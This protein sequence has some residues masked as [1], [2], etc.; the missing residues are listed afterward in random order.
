MNTGEFTGDELADLADDFNDVDLAPSKS[1]EDLDRALFPPA[2][3]D[4]P[5]DMSID[6]FPISDNILPSPVRP[7]ILISPENK[8]MDVNEL[9]NVDQN[10]EVFVKG[11][12]KLLLELPEYTDDTI[13]EWV[14]KVSPLCSKNVFNYVYIQTLITRLSQEYSVSGQNTG[15]AMR[16]ISAELQNAVRISQNGSKITKPFDNAIQ[17]S[18]KEPQSDVIIFISE[19]SGSEK[20][21]AGDIVKVYKAY[22]DPDHAP[23][24][25]CLQ[26]T[27][28][29]NVLL[30]DVFVKGEQ[31][32]Q[33]V[34][35]KLYL[36]AYA[37]SVIDL[38]DGTKQTGEL[39]PTLNKL[40]SLEKIL[41][42]WSLSTDFTGKLKTL[43]EYLDVPITSMALLFWSKSKLKNGDYVNDI[44]M[45]RV[46]PLFYLLD[47]MGYRRK[48]QLK[49]LL[50]IW[51]EILEGIIVGVS[52][53]EEIHLRKIIVDRLINMVKTG[54]VIPILNY[55]Y[56]AVERI[57]ESLV[58][59]FLAKFLGLLETPIPGE[60][61][62][63]VIR[64]INKFKSP[65]LL[66]SIELAD[67]MLFFIRT[68]R[69]K[70]N[71]GKI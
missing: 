18:A 13:S 50:N 70:V 43:F 6:S 28:F 34:H 44:M 3:F 12:V 32:P 60:V 20:P 67:P 29:L 30:N 58:S 22:S 14:A 4:P 2:P 37:S 7:T 16:R 71:A 40:E 23:S 51:I 63:I 46:P 8:I 47:E 66:L 61:V 10:L 17:N 25:S 31:R 15:Y 11:L 48:T 36:L 69:F 24:V 33:Q 52:V 38:H 57:D 53:L 56:H 39:M 55:F 35:E 5:T 41:S 26:S 64:T 27:Q 1:V 68:L 21:L 42:E 49:L 65:K 19:I 59:Y 62:K 9:P 45:G 54:F